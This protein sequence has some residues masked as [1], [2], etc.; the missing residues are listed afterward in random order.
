LPE[1]VAQAIAA[2]L[3]MFPATDVLLAWRTPDGPPRRVRL[4]ISREPGRAV[5]RTNWNERH[6][7]PAVVRA[8]MV[9][10]RDAGPH[11][12]RHRFASL[13]VASGINIR[14]VAEWMGHQDGG[15]L[16]LRTYA[17]LLPAEPEMLRKQLEAALALG[18]AEIVKV[19]KDHVE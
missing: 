15:A 16:L 5:Q 14:Q 13:L 11:Q 18:E 3:A 6:W 9:R 7:M 4:L 19:L 1:G 17:H 12:L 10:G 8:G 2:H